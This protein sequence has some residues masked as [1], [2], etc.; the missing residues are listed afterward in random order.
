[1]RFAWRRCIIQILMFANTEQQRWR[2]GKR[3][4]AVLCG[5][6]L[7]LG[8]GGWAATHQG[9]AS[10]APLID[11]PAA[12]PA[13]SDVLVF[14]SGAVAHPG[15]Y[16][17]SPDARV[18][19]AVAAAGGITAAADPG[20]LPDLAARV[21]D[22]R[23]VN[24]PFVK[25]GSSVAAKLDINTASVDELDSVP[26][27]PPGLVDAIVQYRTE[28][29]DFTSLSELHAVLGV[30]SATVAALGHYLKVVLPPP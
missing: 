8:G 20:H 23:Q 24:I 25:S 27:M 12:A 16:E 13:A 9:S 6:L 18:A 26:G 22:G 14:V 28:W 17:L 10:P 30:D 1:M 5:C 4:I 29:G 11:P 15:L 3:H 21:H 2:V 19:D 7:A